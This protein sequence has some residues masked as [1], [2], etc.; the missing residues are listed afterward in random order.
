MLFPFKL[1]KARNIYFLRHSAKNSAPF[2][3]ILFEEVELRS[4]E[5]SSDTID[6]LCIND[7][8]S[9]PAPMC[10]MLF[11][12]RHNLIKERVL[13]INLANN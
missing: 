12:P 6:E 4:D 3:P 9:H 13:G 10:V 5:R 7:S 2:A 1:R 8:Q 11:D